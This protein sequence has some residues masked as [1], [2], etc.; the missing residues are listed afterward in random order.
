MKGRIF[1][2]LA[3]TMLSSCGAPRIDISVSGGPRPTIMLSQN[4]GFLFGG[5]KP[6]CVWEVAIYAYAQDRPAWRIESTGERS[7]LELGSLTIGTVPAGFRQ[8][9][10]LSGPPHGHYTIVVHGT[11]SGEAAIHL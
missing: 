8:T 2:M 9:V 5:R 11:G 10:P 7:C 1:L 4:W 3:A 6:A